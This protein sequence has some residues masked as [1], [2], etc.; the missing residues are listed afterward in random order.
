M[1]DR[2]SDKREIMDRS[3]AGELSKEGGSFEGG[4]KPRE[5][6]ETKESNLNGRFPS[7]QGICSDAAALYRH[8]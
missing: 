4:V 6:R 2:D 7:N 5:Y 1:R 8:P 3:A